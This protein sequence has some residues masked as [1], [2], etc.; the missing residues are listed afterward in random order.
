MNDAA[1]TRRRTLLA[2]LA[3]LPFA[4]AHAQAAPRGLMLAKVYRDDVPLADYWVSEK[5]D[6]VRA[7]WDGH[8]LWTR[9]GHR[10]HAPATFTAGWPAE[11][12]DGELWAGRGRYTAAASAAARDLPDPVAWRALRYMAFDLP[13]HSGPF[14]ARR[15]ALAQLLPSANSTAMA[16]PQRR[17]ADRAALHALLRE[18]V[19]AGGEGLVLHRGDSLYRGER[20]DALLKLKQHLDAD[21]TVVGHLP[22]KGRHAGRLGALV[23]QTPEGLRFRLGTGMS[24]AQREAPPAIG[25]RVSYRHSGLH[26]NGTPRFASFLRV[27]HD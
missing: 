19:Q 10:I 26:P 16:V 4:S 13:S 18:T 1:L 9:H 2:T 11:P 23:L 17:L 6:G 25:S 22:G 21:A 5:Y 12:L 7:Y 27:R 24:D 14:D 15:T 3:A 8:A 20:S